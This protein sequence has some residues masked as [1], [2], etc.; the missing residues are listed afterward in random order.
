M[1]NAELQEQNTN[2]KQLTTLIEQHKL[3]QIISSISRKLL[4]IR[5][6]DNFGRVVQDCLS[7]LGESMSK[8][9]IYIWKCRVDS[10]GRDYCLKLYRWSSEN[11]CANDGAPNKL[12]YDEFPAFR[13]IANGDKCL[14]RLSRDFAA[15][16]RAI[17]ERQGT[18]AILI[19]PIAISGKLWGFI[20]VDNGEAEQ[21]FSSVEE[22]MLMLSGSLLANAIE[23]METDAA[24]REA[25]ERTQL[26][27]DAMPLCCNLWTSEYKNIR[28]NDEAVRLFELAD[29]SEYLERFFELSP[30]YQPC[31]SP[32]HILA[33]RAIVKA[34]KEG[35]NRF[36]WMHQKL[37]GT[38]M[39]A[40]VTLVR[41][42]YKDSFIVAGYTR[43]LREEKAML[44]ELKTKEALRIAR[45]QALLNS[46]AK[47][48]FLANMSHEIRTPLNA[49]SGFADIILRET[50]NG[51]ATEY[52]QSI[53]DSSN[54]LINIINDILDISKIESGKL[55]ICELPYEFAPLINDV[56]N[57]SRVRL[58][59]K[60]LMFITDIDNHIPA[61]LIGDENRIKQIL[62]NLLSNAIKYTHQG[63]IA[64]RISATVEANHANLRFSVKDSGIGIEQEDLKR[65]FDKFERVDTKKNRNVEGTGL[66]L[67]ICKQL[68]EIM[69]GH[70]QVQSTY[71]EG[72]EFIVDIKQK[73]P[74]FKPLAQISE[75]KTVL[76][77][78]FRELYRHSV[79]KALKKLG[80][81]CVACA[82]QS[83][84]YANI[85]KMQYDYIL[86]AALHLEKVQALIAKYNL[87]VPVAA[88]VD[89]GETVS[90][91]TVDVIPFPINCLQLSALLNGY[92][93]SE[94]SVK[95]SEE[96][97]SFEAPTARVLLVDDN[98][99]N[100]QVAKGLMKPY[101]FEIDTADN[102]MEALAMVKLKNYD[103]VFMDHMMPEMDGVDTTI[104]IRQ[105]NGEYYK[106]LPIIA[107][108][109][110]V[111]AGTKEMFIREGMDDFLAKPIEVNKLVQLL[112]KWLPK[113]KI[114]KLAVEGST[115]T[116]KKTNNITIAAIDTDFG[117]KS[118]G[119]SVDNYLQILATYYTDGLRKLISLP[120]HIANNNL[121]LFRTEIHALK[122]TSATIGALELAAMATQLETAAQSNDY[123]FIKSHLDG[124]MSSLDKVLAA[125]LLKLPSNLDTTDMNSKPAGN[126]NYLQTQLNYLIDSLELA[127][128]RQIEDY[129]NELLQYSWSENINN[130][131]SAIQQY[132]NMFDYDS[133]LECA[134]RLKTIN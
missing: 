9:R 115:T 29:Q 56:I 68:C 131:L 63:Y 102:G 24:L 48:N 79:S 78:E 14:N 2:P 120:Q 126:I 38:P 43:D 107:L 106:S 80:C 59:N 1:N 92:S 23:N 116:D 71:G 77:Y 28:C 104:A 87:S 82:N 125:L 132:T 5:S 101:K 36:E 69:D 127:N 121:A 41:I 54:T 47:S 53:K 18:K 95:H 64:L 3:L 46:K 99:V 26:M 30:K 34:F 117:I 96:V 70:I 55:E 100:L 61:W 4:A 110:N 35:Y 67:A 49:I 108:T 83:E 25:E 58:G 97:S 130:E 65:L 105:L 74:L 20:N 27:L 114:E 128:I 111:L 44:N 122:S 52:A 89:Y 109:A 21:L 60:S 10:D 73:F 12:F 76:L 40:E 32:S 85:N 129:L 112:I 133:A 31:G 7:L 86:T 19:A 17:L 88:F 134:T 22:S 66:G 124:F 93:E 8:N 103:L 75:K 81:N 33:H 57:I 37:D 94:N 13:A 42:K 90:D 118:V 84:L 91:H 51:N 6:N 39:P 72:S 11:N 50:P 62:L 98:P 45:D 113:S 123:G 15:S 119:G 16:E